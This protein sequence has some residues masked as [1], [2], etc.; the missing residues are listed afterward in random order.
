MELSREELMEVMAVFKEESRELLTA[1]ESNTEEL[2][3]NPKSA[4]AIEILHRTSHSLK[5]AARM[6]G[7]TPIEQIGYKLE[8]GFKSAKDGSLSITPDHL[9]LIRDAIGFIRQLTDKLSSNG[10]TDGIDVTGILQK[11]DKFKWPRIP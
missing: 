10:T 7:L 2:A 3:A 5:G 1:L 11:L 4:S 6:L 9:S 8:I